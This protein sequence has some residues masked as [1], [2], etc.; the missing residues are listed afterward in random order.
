MRGVPLTTCYV[1]G[2][3][4][5]L[6]PATCNV[7]RAASRRLDCLRLRRLPVRSPAPPTPRA[8]PDDPVPDEQVARPA[9][10]P[11]ARQVVASWPRDLLCSRG[12]RSYG[13]QER[14]RGVEFPGRPGAGAATCRF[15]EA[16]GIADRQRMEQHGR[17]RGPRRRDTDGRGEGHDRRA[18]ATP[19][20]RRSCRNASGIAYK[21]DSISAITTSPAAVGR[22]RHGGE[23]HGGGRLLT[24]SG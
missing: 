17:Q 5:N 22:W 18:S 1:L 3:T 2:A 8:A 9:P 16:P 20:R 10:A 15:L 19:G 13:D 21:T 11:R 24:A 23:L 6:Q 7:E 12:D 4:C 14:P